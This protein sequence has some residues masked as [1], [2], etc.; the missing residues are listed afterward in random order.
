MYV[1]LHVCMSF[2]VYAFG[3]SV[4]R[5]FV[6]HVCSYVVYLVIPCF[7]YVAMYLFR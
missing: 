6:L 5:P 7:L 1:V 3:R 2:A 4:F